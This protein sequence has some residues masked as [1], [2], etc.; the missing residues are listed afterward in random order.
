MN[1]PLK[2]SLTLLVK[3]GSLIIHHEESA[4]PDGHHFDKIAILNPSAVYEETMRCYRGYRHLRPGA[5]HRRT[6]SRQ[7]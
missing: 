1:D 2:P 6:E 5:V 7:G 3:L 4:S